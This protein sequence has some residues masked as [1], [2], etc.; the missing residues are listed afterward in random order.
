MHR[1]PPKKYYK[2][3]LQG[4]AERR[5]GAKQIEARKRN[6]DAASVP[7]THSAYLLSY[8]LE[9]TRRKLSRP[10]VSGGEEPCVIHD[11]ITDLWVVP[12]T[13]LTVT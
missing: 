13:S 12:E 7:E 9:P 6:E 5:A 1:I 8:N 4:V 3:Q 11:S 10:T 2:E